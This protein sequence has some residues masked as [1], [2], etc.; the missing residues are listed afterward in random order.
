MT[1]RPLCIAGKT[2]ECGLGT[3]A[4]SE[5]VLCATAPLSRFKALAGWDDNPDTRNAKPG[6]QMTFVVKAGGKTLWKSA[7]VALGDPAVPV[8]VVLPKGTTEVTLEV[9]TSDGATGYAHA[10][11]VDVAAK[12]D[13]G[14][15]WKPGRGALAM[16]AVPA[17]APFSF[18][19]DGRPS[20]G[21]LAGWKRRQD[22]VAQRGR[23]TVH[24]TTWRDPAVAGGPLHDQGF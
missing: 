11:W 13:G 21:F 6:N 20:S 5:V 9:A 16:Q 24:A 18:E 19:Y 14:G 3:H 23:R 4:A 22:K 12:F 15:W 1:R 7:P 17:I 8:D 2:W 10:D